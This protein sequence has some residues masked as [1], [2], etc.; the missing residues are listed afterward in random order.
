[1]T[2]ELTEEELNEKIMETVQALE[3]IGE[4][5]L[6]NRVFKKLSLKI[7]FIELDDWVY[8]QVC[9]TFPKVDV[10]DLTF[11]CSPANMCPYRTAVLKKLG[12]SLEDYIHMKADVGVDIADKWW[13]KKRGGTSILRK[14]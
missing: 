3:E 4:R 1:M 2:E 9:S 6:A 7:E 12:L 14:L 8:H 11:C 10:R 13:K 5:G